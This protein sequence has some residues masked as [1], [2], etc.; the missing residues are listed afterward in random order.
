[1]E[2][3]DKG[4]TSRLPEGTANQGNREVQQMA[5]GPGG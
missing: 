1:L 5:R 2:R 4:R 3:M